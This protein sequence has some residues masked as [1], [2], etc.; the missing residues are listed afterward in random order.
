MRVE[1]R[2]T[3]RS[4]IVEL[5][6][7]DAQ[8][9]ETESKALPQR[10][11]SE[12]SRD[13]EPFSPVTDEEEDGAIIETATATRVGYDSNHIAA[14]KR[15]STL[16]RD[17]LPPRRQS[18]LP[19]AF[20][21]GSQP[22]RSPI[23]EYTAPR[24][25]QGTSHV[26][27]GYVRGTPSA[28]L[29]AENDNTPPLSRN[30]VSP[31]PLDESGVG[32]VSSDTTLQNSDPQSERL[33][34]Y[35]Y[36]TVEST[37]WL[38]TIDE[39]GDDSSQSVHSRR[40]SIGLRRKHIR[41]PSGATEAEFDAALDAAVEAAYDDGF[42][43]AQDSVAAMSPE[44]SI[45]MSKGDSISNARR[46]VELAKQKVREAE[47]EA[48][49]AMAT[50][51]TIPR[52]QNKPES[53]DRSDSIELEYGDEEAEEEERILEEMTK[54]YVMDDTEF[55]VRSKSALPRQS[56]SS[57]FS[58]RTWGSSIGSNPTTGG[59]SLSTVAELT[60]LPELPSE[61]VPKPV[62]PPP[63]NPPPTAALP[64][65]PQI[66][67]GSGP[68]APPRAPPPRPPSLG[69][70]PSPSVRERRLSGHKFTHLKIET[71]AKVPPGMSAPRTQPPVIPPPALSAEALVEPP[72]SA[73]MIRESLQ[74][75]PSHGLE[76][77]SLLIPPSAGSQLPSSQASP[78][79]IDTKANASPA[80]P[81]LTKATST[82]SEESTL[83]LSNSPVRVKKSSVLPGGLRK[84]F[85][86]SSLKGRQISVSTPNAS[87][88]S[89][90][91]PLTTAFSR[92]SHPNGSLPELPATKILTD[93]MPSVPFA[94]INFFDHDIKSPVSPTTPNTASQLAP[95]PLEPCPESFLLR[96]FW[97]MRCV[98]NTIAHPRGGYISS[99]L[100]VPR[101]IWRVKNV[102]VKNIE[103]K[104]S[105]CDLLTA[106]LLKLATV[107]T[108]DADAVL[109]EMQAFENVLD[110]V[111]NILSKKLGAEVGVHGSVAMFKG[112]GVID[113]AGL[114]NEVLTSKIPNT[115]SKSY[116]STW[117]KL[118]SK[119]SSAPG[120]P[121]NVG[122]TNGKEGS[123]DTLMMRSLP[124]TNMNNPKLPKRDVSKVQC[125]G[126]NAN[127]M[128]SLARL[129]D[130]VQVL[131]ECLSSGRR[132][133]YR[134]NTD[135]YVCRQIKLRAK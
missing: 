33:Q 58:G 25:V 53:R 123:R 113:E 71:N 40:S 94:G 10:P 47:R 73:I 45:Y 62:P 17:Q 111:Q 74:T 2:N 34:I 114:P 61:D 69:I 56:D 66:A 121:I 19:F 3:Y 128:G 57:G 11:T 90:S 135:L 81:A 44:Q 29:A 134:S 32:I 105:N 86:S 131:G 98:F 133:V 6:T 51:R 87:D 95:S 96:P 63:P 50:N 37:S 112:S 119:N 23:R 108:L 27:Q 104:I 80:T 70:S 18:L 8:S 38:D 7:T 75:L 99:G 52:P 72:K 36:E 68:G 102:K 13:Q 88:D 97:V 77:A 49:I 24:P 78:S 15:P 26:T 41:A 12:E 82:D 100:F 130:A 9:P 31:L 76:P 109:E 120:L 21:D 1:K 89:P 93:P 110:Q 67:S 129:C 60:I 28:A 65:P 84:N 39:S 22:S 124:M 5:E 14:Q 20:D 126:P 107:D 42:E 83:P 116:L 16:T 46:N 35:R 55:D 118:R 122:A 48:T 115:N 64:P 54:D 125:I 43:P 79:A 91:T 101:D 85:S 92:T 59:T 127:Y 30:D 117:R 4:R 106:A 103:E 132:P